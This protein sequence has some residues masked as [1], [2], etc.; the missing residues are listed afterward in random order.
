MQTV[1]YHNQL[2]K[3]IEVTKERIASLISHGLTK[4]QINEFA[5][6]KVFEEKIPENYGV[7]R[8]FI[9]TDSWESTE[10]DII[11]YDK[12]YPTLFKTGDV[13]I[14][15]PDAVKGLI[16]VKTRLTSQELME[17]SEK[18]G[19]IA[20]VVYNYRSEI[21]GAP[22]TDN[23]RFDL[24]EEIF[25]GIIGIE[26]PNFKFSTIETHL[27][28]AA[29]G[30]KTRVV[31]HVSINEKSFVKYF[32]NTSELP[33]GCGWHIYKFT[34]PLAPAYFLSN[35]LFYLNYSSVINNTNVWFPYES[36]NPY[37]KYKFLL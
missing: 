13:I 20:E 25:V 32:G 37:F 27:K 11:I 30:L 5:I 1:R 28:N 15:T 12:S 6:K 2:Y 16:E 17:S 24:K 3:E 29:R 33:S 34:D 23:P 7:S 14:V 19:N 35:S 4:G 10:I 8:G 22:I 26:G 36:K 31:N 21:L 18:L 9:V